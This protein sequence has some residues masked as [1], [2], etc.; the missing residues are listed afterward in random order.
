[1]KSAFL[2]T[3]I[4]GYTQSKKSCNALAMAGGGAK[5]A[6]EAGALW[7]MYN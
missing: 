1:M 6:F 3:L 4:F 7:G 5:G 2:S